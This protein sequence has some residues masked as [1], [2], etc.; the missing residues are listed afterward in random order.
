[1]EYSHVGN[2]FAWYSRPA[3][4]S[5][6]L[7]QSHPSIRR[8][9]TAGEARAFILGLPGF[10][11]MFS[12]GACCFCLFICGC[13]GKGIFEGNNGCRLWVGVESVWAWLSVPKSENQIANKC[14]RTTFRI[15]A[16]LGLL[17]K[18]K[19]FNQ[20]NLKQYPS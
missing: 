2:F 1:M 18:N 13:V 9:S 4:R 19:L 3:V 17:N 7:I 8:E 11:I 6:A 20:R 12:L 5:L 15:V 10:E 14:V 16:V